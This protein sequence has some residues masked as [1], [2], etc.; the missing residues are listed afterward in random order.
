MY[1]NIFTLSIANYADLLAFSFLNKLYFFL[2]LAKN[3]VI[4]TVSNIFLLKT[5][6]VIGKSCT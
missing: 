4:L 2:K 1:F 3:S 5:N 6:Y